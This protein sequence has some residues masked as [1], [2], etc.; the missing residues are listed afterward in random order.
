MTPPT[1]SSAP[2]PPV[3]AQ[4]VEQPK[5]KAEVKQPVAPPPV[6]PPLEQ[7]P[8]PTAT[9]AQPKACPKTPPPPAKSLPTFTMRPDS[10]LAGIGLGGPNPFVKMPPIETD[11]EAAM[12]RAKNAL[13]VLNGSKKEGGGGNAL[14]AIGA[15]LAQNVG[16]NFANGAVF[17]I[18]AS[19]SFDI[20]KGKPKV[21]QLSVGVGGKT[22]V[23]PLGVKK[24]VITPAPPKPPPPKP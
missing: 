15:D 12:A 23:G 8:V 13:T 24:E 1:N 21:V 17:S 16:G 10:P 22:P 3:K 20:V 6:Q 19:G 14:D 18:G 7:P 11:E 2:R 4:P 5:P 9:T